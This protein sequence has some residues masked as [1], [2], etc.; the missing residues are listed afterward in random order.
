MMKCPFERI[1]FKFILKR[2]RQKERQ[3]EGERRKENKYECFFI[4]S[5]ILFKESFKHK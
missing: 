4:D 2:K 1:M 5:S 3:R